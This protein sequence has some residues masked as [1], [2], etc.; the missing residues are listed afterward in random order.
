MKP[1]QG[2]AKRVTLENLPNFAAMLR[3]AADQTGGD[4]ENQLDRASTDPAFEAAEEL[5]QGQPLHVN[6]GL[7]RPRGERRRQ[8]G[9]R[10]GRPPVS[11]RRSFTEA[12]YHYPQGTHL[13]HILTVL[14]SLREGT[15]AGGPLDDRYIR[16]RG[17]LGTGRLS[18][19][20]RQ[21]KYKLQAS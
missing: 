5:F 18:A 13:G 20:R 3:R 10:T 14:K 6:L 11:S 2:F 9:R 8:P 1:G 4:S 12:G 17:N 21:V 15:R 7:T 19:Y 16:M